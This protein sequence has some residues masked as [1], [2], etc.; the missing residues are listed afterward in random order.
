MSELFWYALEPIGIL[1]MWFLI[2]LWVRRNDE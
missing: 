2:T 1:L